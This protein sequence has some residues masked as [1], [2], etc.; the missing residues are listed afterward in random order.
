VSG[1]EIKTLAAIS[2]RHI[3]DL[4]D[5]LIDCVE[6]GASVGFMM[7]LTHAK[8]ESFWRGLSGSVER[9]ERV[10]LVA[11]DLGSIVGTVQIVLAQPENQAH[12]ADI[13]KMLV[14]RRV[15][16]GGIGAALLAAAERAA[17]AAGKTLLVL[18]TASRDAARLYE[19]RGWRRCG[20]VPGFALLPL[21]GLCDTTYFYRVL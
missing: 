5:V 18:D 12:R 11:E 10:V 21:G 4:S 1:I 9:G 8:A 14:H 6:G 17:R 3:Q 16:R 15:R 20:V 2:E 13:A 19:R 7:P